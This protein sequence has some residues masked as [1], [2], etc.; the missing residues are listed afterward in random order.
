MHKNS[1]DICFE[2]A[3]NCYNRLVT[4]LLSKKVIWQHTMLWRTMFTLS[5]LFAL[6]QSQSRCLIQNGGG[7]FDL[8]PL[9]SLPAV[10][11][12]TDFGRVIVNFCPSYFSKSCAVQLQGNLFREVKFKI[13]AKCEQSSRNLNFYF[14]QPFLP[15]ISFCSVVFWKKLG[16]L[17]WR[18]KLVSL[19][20]Q[21]EVACFCL[22]MFEPSEQAQL[23]TM[24]SC[25][26]FSI[27]HFES[28]IREIFTS[29]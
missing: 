24:K 22:F 4:R 25:V 19:V 20:T 29:F 18:K 7:V 28:K 2:N 8:T 5:L 13:G 27:F 26:F 3:G 15:W 16:E 10:I 1:T 17:V 9:G 6:V 11:Q 12:D 23:Q 21:I 14:W